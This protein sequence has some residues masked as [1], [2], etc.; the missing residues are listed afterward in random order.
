MA[1]RI[2]VH[3][4][5]INHAGDCDPLETI[6]NDINEDALAERVRSISNTDIRV[7]SIEQ[8]NGFWLFDFAKFRD[9]HGPGKATRQTP[10]VGFEFMENE[11]FCEETAALY[12]PTT[13]HMIVQYN[14]YGVRAGAIECYLSEYNGPDNGWYEFRPKYDQDAENRFNRRQATRK[15]SFSIDPRMLNEQDRVAGTA[16]SQ[17]I[18]IGNQS[19]ASKIE[20][21][22]TVGRERRN[23]LSEYADRTAVALK[24]KS[25]ENPNAVP[26]LQVGILENLDSTVEVVDLIEQRLFREFTDIQLGPDRRYPREERYQALIRAHRGWRRILN[27]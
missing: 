25:E 26:R 14:H 20:V 21:T 12:D 15:L 6:L 3:A 16:L 13:R 23:V 27:Q 4:F 2:K 11:V 9:E 19:N 7:E 24:L 1:G 10:I 8:R 17:A 18:D 22:I 5:G